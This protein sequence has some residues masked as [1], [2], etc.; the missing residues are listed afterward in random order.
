MIDEIIDKTDVSKPT[1][2][3]FLGAL[4]SLVPQGLKLFQHF[5]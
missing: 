1:S 5:T 2:E 3:E 4:N